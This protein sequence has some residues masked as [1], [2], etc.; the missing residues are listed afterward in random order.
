M[1][2]MLELVYRCRD[3]RKFLGFTQQQ[4][5]K[6]VGVSHQSVSDFERGNNNSAEIF[7]WYVSQGFGA[8]LEDMKNIIKR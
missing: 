8:E 7:A 1:V 5:A 6:D 4:V 3:Y 2:D